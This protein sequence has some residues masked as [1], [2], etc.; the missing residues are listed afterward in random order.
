MNKLYNGINIYN[1][2]TYSDNSE[3]RDY[4]GFL[5]KYKTQF[6]VPDNVN[7]VELNYDINSAM[8][9]D[10]YRSYMSSF[11]NLV[12][13]DKRVLIYNGQNDLLTPTAGI[14]TVL[15]DLQWKGARDWR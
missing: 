12:S 4:L 11:E 2:K 1:Y 9:E 14:V 5:K 8:S 10:M 3:G 7:F 6:G 15:Q 13:S